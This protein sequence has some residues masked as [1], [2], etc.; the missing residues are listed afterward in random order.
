MGSNQIPGSFR[1]RWFRISSPRL[2]LKLILKSNEASR[3]GFFTPLIPNL[4]SAT[5]SRVPSVSEPGH[6]RHPRE[7]SWNICE[8]EPKIDS[9]WFWATLLEYG[10]GELPPGTW[11][12][13][14]KLDVD[15]I[16]GVFSCYFRLNEP[17]ILSGR[18][19]SSAQ[20]WHQRPTSDTWCTHNWI[21]TLSPG[22]SIKTEYSIYFWQSLILR[23][24]FG[25]VDLIQGENRGTE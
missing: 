8:N 23:Y 5:I 16:P 18:F 25:I 12:M 20:I 19:L 4:A 6:R 7:F 17:K 13:Y 21:L 9:R 10:I 22:I 1:G 14:R 2:L 11:G 24:L 15:V 3:Q